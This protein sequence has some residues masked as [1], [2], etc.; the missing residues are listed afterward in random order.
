MKFI[1][2]HI[3]KTAGTTMRWTLFERFYKGR[4]LYDDMFKLKRNKKTETK[5]LLIIEN[6]LYPQVNFENYDAIFGH[7]KYDKY[8][9]LKRPM[10]S[11]VR[12]PV[13]RMISNYNYFKGSYKRKGQNISLIEFSEMWKNHMTYILG[14]I[15]K[16]EYIGVVESFQKSLNKM[17]GI[18]G[19]KTPIKIMTKRVSHSYKPNQVSKKIRNRIKNMNLEDMKL[20]EEVVKKWQ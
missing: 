2:V 19:I 7:F 6:Q 16:Y 8:E 17:C 18:L 15:S 11:F 1:Y 12:H 20:Y 10:F 4:Y 9:H 13:D 14:D 3:L 5:N